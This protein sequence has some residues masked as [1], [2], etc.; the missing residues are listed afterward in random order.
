MH[1]QKT[2]NTYMFR[3]ARKP[4]SPSAM[5][6]K[7]KPASLPA[8]E[9]YGRIWPGSSHLSAILLSV[10]RIYSVIIQPL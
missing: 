1:V 5:N 3:E 9:T 7:R 6:K 4:A 8:T 10:C 2:F